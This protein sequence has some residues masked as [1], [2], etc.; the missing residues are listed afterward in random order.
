MLRPAGVATSGCPVG[1]GGLLGREKA[2][3]HAGFSRVVTSGCPVGVGALGWPRGGWPAY[4]AQQGQRHGAALWAW[5]PRWLWGA[6][7]ACCAQQWW[8][9]RALLWAWGPW[10]PA[11]R[12]GSS[13]GCVR[14]PCG[15]GNSGWLRGGWPVCWAQR[16][17]RHGAASW[18]WMSWVP[19][20]GQHCL[21][22]LAGRWRNTCVAQKFRCLCPEHA[23]C[24]GAGHQLLSA[25]LA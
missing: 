5:D 2:G 8:R 10:L 1:L 23:S 9:H 12:L 15:Q 14:L 3:R 22:Y 20:G 11:R 6:W 13:L 17:W 4:W 16:G 18:A 25:R 24:L 21:D 19:L 7:P